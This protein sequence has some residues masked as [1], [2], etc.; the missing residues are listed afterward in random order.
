MLLYVKDVIKLL[1]TFNQNAVLFVSCDSE[2]NNISP[3]SKT[4]ATGTL[5]F[6]KK[7]FDLNIKE[8]NQLLDQTKTITL[9]PQI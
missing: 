2:G 1:Q 6:D 7:Y 5:D 4:Y 8:L 9:F 3:L